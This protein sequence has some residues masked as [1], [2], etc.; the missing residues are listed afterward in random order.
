MITTDAGAY[1]RPWTDLR[2]AC[3]YQNMATTRETDAQLVARC[4]AGDED[5]WRELVDRFSRYVYAIAV[6]GFR[7][8]DADAEDVFQ[9][10]FARAYER[11][12]NLRDDEAFK[13]WLAQLTRRICIDARRVSARE[14][15]SQD[16]VIYELEDT[17]GRLDEALALHEALALLPDHCQEILDRFFAR[18][19]SY[20]TIGDAL[21][22]PAG[23]IA[24]R[25]SRCLVKLRESLE[26]RNQGVD[27]S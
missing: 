23:T 18:D 26:G 22:I 25:I 24:S 21:E 15:L 7:L 5:A 3:Q 8:S 19:E 13:P 16:E 17:L 10:V 2:K 4:R 14:Q 9:E 11:L 12:R 6:Q 27:E 20:R 1:K